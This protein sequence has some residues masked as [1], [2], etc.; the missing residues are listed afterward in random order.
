MGLDAPEGRKWGDRRSPEGTSGEFFPNPDPVAR[1]RN[2]FAN[3][4]RDVT[5][6]F[7]NALRR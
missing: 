4:V 1:Y 7:R 6:N 5:S 2:F 3:C